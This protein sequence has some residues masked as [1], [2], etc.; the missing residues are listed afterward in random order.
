MNKKLFITPDWPAPSGIQAYTTL[1]ASNVSQPP[2]TKLNREQVVQ[3]LKLPNEPT[4]LHQIHSDIVLP[5]HPENTGKDADASYS[6][7]V[8]QI[9]IIQT[10]DCLPILLC[11]KQGTHIA[12]IHAGWRGLAKNIIA[13]TIQTLQQPGSELLAW[14]GPGISQPNYEVGDEVRKTF[15]DNDPETASAFIPS[16]NQRWLADLYAIAKLQLRK[17]KVTAIYGADFCTYSDEKNFF[18]Y[19]RDGVD[20]G[21][22]VSAIWLQK[23]F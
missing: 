2:H 10:A 6:N 11:N 20:T 16:P 18:S 12:A 9:C 23:K 17:Q 19:R 14:I 5:A 8:N 13:K 15:I 3:I 7:Q 22:I 1:K 21:R 4:W